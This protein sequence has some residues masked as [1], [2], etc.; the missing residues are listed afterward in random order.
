MLA[1]PEG[2]TAGAVSLRQEGLWNSSGAYL[3]TCQR[4]PTFFPPEQL[5]GE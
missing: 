5:N 3:S 4:S 1:R 2:L